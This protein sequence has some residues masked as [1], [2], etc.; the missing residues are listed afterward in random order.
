MLVHF[1]PYHGTFF[2]NSFLASSAVFAFLV[3]SG[4]IVSLVYDNRINETKDLLIFYKKRFFRMYPMHVLFLFT[5]LII[6]FLKLYLENEY[7]IIANNKS[8]TI[9][10]GSAFI[11]HLLLLNIFNNILTYNLPAWTV[12]GEFITSILFGLSCLFIKNKKTK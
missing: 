6:E 9:N 7:N 1:N 10:D 12:S 11:S 2:H 8:F 4:F 5:F 3:L